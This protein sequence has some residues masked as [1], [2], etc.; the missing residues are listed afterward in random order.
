MVTPESG[1]MGGTPAD[2]IPLSLDREQTEIT[3]E[4]I[5]Q[6]MVASGL[7]DDWTSAR[8]ANLL[9]HKARGNAFLAAAALN[10]LGVPAPAGGH[11]DLVGPPCQPLEL[12]LTELP[13]QGISRD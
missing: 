6:V 2:V 11:V 1:T 7:S 12:S 3:A 13:E 9:L 8:A 5:A 10:V 4:R